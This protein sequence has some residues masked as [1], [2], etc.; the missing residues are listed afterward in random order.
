MNARVVTERGIGAERLPVKNTGPLQAVEGAG[1]M[2]QEVY[3]LGNLVALRLVR[4]IGPSS[5]IGLW[6]SRVHLI[7]SIRWL[8]GDLSKL[9]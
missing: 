1:P 3:R 9:A 5:H 6:L 2:Q 7:A 4:S 8:A